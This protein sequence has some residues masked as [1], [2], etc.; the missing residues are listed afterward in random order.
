MMW[1][2]IILHISKGNTLHLLG[3]W[4]FSFSKIKSLTFNNGISYLSP[5]DRLEFIV[6]TVHSALRYPVLNEHGKLSF[7]QKYC[8][9][10]IEK[11]LIS[12]HSVA[13]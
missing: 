11:K 5:P 4:F 12:K 8:K 7:E 6:V 3:V 9:A 2:I 13:A 1:K 10:N